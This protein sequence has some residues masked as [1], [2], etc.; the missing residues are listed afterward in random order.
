M[1]LTLESLAKRVETLESELA[2]IR[3]E[4]K[5]VSAIRPGTGN[6]DA[7][8]KAIEELEDYD[9]EALPEQNRIDLLD[10]ENR[11]K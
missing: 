10:A 6:W 11:H 4:R 1:E 5:I 3:G 8:F 2:R 9:Y 7:A